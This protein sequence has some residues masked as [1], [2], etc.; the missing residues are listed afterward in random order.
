MISQG[1][2]VNRGPHL[3]SREAGCLHPAGD[4]PPYLAFGDLGLEQLSC[5]RMGSAVSKAGAHCSMRSP[6]ARAMGGTL[7]RPYTRSAIRL[8]R[9]LR[10]DFSPTPVLKISGNIEAAMA[11]SGFISCSLRRRLTTRIMRQVWSVGIS[12]LKALPSRGGR[13]GTPVY[14]AARPLLSAQT[15]KK[16]QREQIEGEGILGR[17]L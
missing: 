10:P 1:C 6:A 8:A 16:F 11:T 3:A 12:S 17:H 13:A 14:F 4:G 9:P 7:D 5:E 2:E 15:S